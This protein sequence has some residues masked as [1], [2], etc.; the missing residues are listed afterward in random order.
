MALSVPLFLVPGCLK[1][2]ARSKQSVDISKP[3]ASKTTSLTHVLV[4]EA[5]S[6]GEV[7][8]TR[9]ERRCEAR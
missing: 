4:S 7:V 2:L 6:E 1:C 3:H 8:V 9:Q 5:I